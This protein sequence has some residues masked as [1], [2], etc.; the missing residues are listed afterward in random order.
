MSYRSSYGR[1]MRSR[2]WG[3]YHHGKL[4]ATIK[5]PS[6]EAAAK[7]FSKHNDRNPEFAVKGNEIK[8][9]ND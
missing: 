1:L 6:W 5:A 7:E 2:T 4:V 9:V 3:L 8:E